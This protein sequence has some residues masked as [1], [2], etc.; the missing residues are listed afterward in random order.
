MEDLISKFYPDDADELR[1]Q[2]E[3]RPV[4]VRPIITLADAEK[5]YITRY[6]IR[7]TNDELFV[8]EVDQKQYDNLKDNPRFV[9]TEVKWKIVG[10]KE[11]LTYF[12]GAS[13]YGVADANLQAVSKA[14][15][16][17][18]GLLRYIKDYTEFWYAER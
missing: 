16:T 8:T 11:T 12:S 2:M 5:K 10:R 7:Q 13:D 17:F 9:A 14:D 4:Y 15:L 3:V 6:F 1:E 18:G